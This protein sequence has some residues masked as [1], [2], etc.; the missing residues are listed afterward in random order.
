MPVTLAKH[1][2]TVYDTTL[3]DIDTGWRQ[4]VLDHIEFIKQNS[5]MVVMN[6]N[7]LLRYRFN[8]EWLLIEKGSKPD[9][10]WIFFLINKLDGDVRFSIEWISYYNPIWY[11]PTYDY[12]RTLRSEYD[13]T[14]KEVINSGWG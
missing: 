2:K 14:S 3:L 8:V 7:T 11:I 5:T 6:N 10:K 9:L 4:Y 12:I 13:N 1:L